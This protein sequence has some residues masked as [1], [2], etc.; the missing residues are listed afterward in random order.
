MKNIL[1][2][3]GVKK[4]DRKTQKNITGGGGFC[5]PGGGFCC[6]VVQGT[7]Q[8]EPGICTRFGGCVFL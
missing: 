7:L 3:S 5:G 4:L 1:K 6:F 8:C 2:N